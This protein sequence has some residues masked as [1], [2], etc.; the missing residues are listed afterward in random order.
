MK[1]TA[2]FLISLLLLGCNNHRLQ[3]ISATSSDDNCLV[4]IKEDS[5]SWPVT[6]HNLHKI[7]LPK[8]N[9]D[10]YLYFGYGSQFWAVCDFNKIIVKSNFEI[11][12]PIIGGWVAISDNIIEIRLIKNYGPASFNGQFKIINTLLRVNN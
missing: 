8:V 2:F 3:V 10:N 9:G 12:G 11:G 4:S 1:K 5:R 7:I 6:I